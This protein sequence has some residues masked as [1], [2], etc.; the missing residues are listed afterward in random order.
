MTT[1]PPE[2]KAL[3][4]LNTLGTTSYVMICYKHPNLQKLTS[5]VRVILKPI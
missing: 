3:I 5:N 2:E 4:I 1:R